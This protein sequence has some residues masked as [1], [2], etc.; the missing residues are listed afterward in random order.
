MESCVI[1]CVSLGTASKVVSILCG[2]PLRLCSSS[3]K[4][5]VSSA[6][7]TS[8][9]RSSQKAASGKAASPPGALG[10]SLLQSKSDLPNLSP[11]TSSEHPGTGRLQRLPDPGPLDLSAPLCTGITLYFHRDDRRPEAFRSTGIS[12][13]TRSRCT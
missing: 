9:V 11:R 13:G 3:V 4:A 2:M 12:T 10:S 5:F 1:G 7:G 8:P 6:V